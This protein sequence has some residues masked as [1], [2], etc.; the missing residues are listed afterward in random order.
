MK[1]GLFKNFILDDENNKGSVMITVLVAFLFV[2]VL[3]AIILS[4]VTV[5]F[6]MR[7]VD[8]STKDEFY[9]A[10]KTLNDLYNGI[11]Q[12]CSAIMGKAYNEV[13]AEYKTTGNS[14]YMDEEKAYKA[15]CEKFVTKFYTDI[16]ENQSTKFPGYIVKDTHK[17][18]GSD[19]SSRAIV[20]SYGEIKYYKDS[21]RADA[22]EI[23]SVNNPNIKDVGLIVVR[24]VKIQS[25]PDA[26]E[27]IGY[28]QLAPIDDGWE[29]GYHVAKKYTGNGYATEAVSA[30]V[31][32]AADQP[33]VSRIEA[34]TEEENEA[35]K[36]VLIRCGFVPT[37][38][39]GEEGPRFVLK[40]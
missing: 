8:R 5:N 30:A 29:I 10:E 12:D 3:A 6:Q 7:A 32:W 13:L 25:N 9:Y 17:K 35:S 15:F 18:G 34:E 39:T 2:A 36:K 16:A 31:R 21:T 38:E 19:A 22:L 40:Q 37:G 33:G 23:D 28:V 27:N 20:K 24:G 11:G 1:N 4:T 26:N 14:S